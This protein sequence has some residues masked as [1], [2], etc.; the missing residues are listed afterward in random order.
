MLDEKAAVPRDFTAAG[1]LNRPADQS[2]HL[3]EVSV[4]RFPVAD[5]TSGFWCGADFVHLPQSRGPSFREPLC[6]TANVPQSSRAKSTFEPRDL[7]LVASW[8][9]QRNEWRV[10]VP[11]VLANN[12]EESAKFTVLA[13]R[14]GEI[15]Q[16]N[17]EQ[18][19]S[20]GAPKFFELAQRKHQRG[21]RIERQRFAKHR[22]EPFEKVELGARNPGCLSDA[23]ARHQGTSASLPNTLRCSIN[24][25]ASTALANGITACTC[26]LI[27]PSATHCSTSAQFARFR[28]GFFNA[29]KPQ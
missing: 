26:G 14:V 9:Q 24:S 15:R 28:S 25:S 16:A 8:F 20:T 22:A 29:K 17:F 10:P 2:P 23:S 18:A 7:P 5:Q 27:R 13:Q 21:Q 12:H 1:P 19:T 11:K 4:A 3:G 6:L